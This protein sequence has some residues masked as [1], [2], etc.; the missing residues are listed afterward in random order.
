MSDG[1]GT[2][3]GQDGAG[4]PE[5][6]T[7]ST[8]SGAGAAPSG[9]EAGASGA[10]GEAG[11]SRAGAGAE[12]S[13]AGAGAGASRAGAGA[14]VGASRAD[15][16]AEASRAGADA[17]A[18]R[19][20]TEAD[21]VRGERVPSGVVRLL[22]HSAPRRA[23]A[24]TPL[25]L[26]L[27]LLTAV[28]ALVASAGPA[29]V[30]RLAGNALAGR[31]AEAQRNAPGLEVFATFGPADT[32]LPPS[33]A[34]VGDL[35]AT[36]HLILGSA[37]RPLAGKVA[38]DSTRIEI[39][40]GHTPTPGGEAG[41]TLVLPD[42]APDARSYVAGRP[43]APLGDSLEIAVSTRT[44]DAL[45]LRLGQRLDLKARPTFKQVD[46]PVRVVGFFTP[47]DSRL[48]REIPPLT[49][50]LQTSPPNAPPTWQAYAIIGVGS[51][52][53]IQQEQNFDLMAVWRFRL[54]FDG[55]AATPLATGRGPLGLRQSVMKYAENAAV[56][57]CGTPQLGLGGYP[58]MLGRHE[59]TE[60][61]SSGRLLATVE[62][63]ERDWARVRVLIAF[64]PASL[65][66]VG[67]AACAVASL[68]A[69]RRRLPELRLRRARGA[70]ALHLACAAGA[71]T[72]PLVLVGWA[73]GVLLARQS[74][75]EGPPPPGGLTALYLAL[76]V[77]LLLP[78]LTWYALRD[79]ALH[80]PIRTRA[81]RIRS[82]AR[83]RLTLEGGLLLLTGAGVQALRSRAPAAEPDLQLAVVPA[84]LGVAAVIVLVRCYPA[85]VRWAARRSARRRGTVPLLALSRAAQDAP[86]RA[87]VLLVLVTSLSTAVFGGL[88]ARTLAEGRRD[89]VRWQTGAN[90][91]YVA[92]SLD[93]DTARRL[94]ATP[95]VRH[96]VLI[97]HRT[98]DLRD[99][100]TGLG[101]GD[102]ALETL[103]G[104]ALR[105]ADP[106]SAVARALAGLPPRQGREIPVLADPPLRRGNVYLAALRG[107]EARVKVVGPLPG[108]AGRDPA[109]GPLR[110]DSQT[111]LLLADESA[112]RGLG[113][114]LPTV[115]KSALL[116]YGPDID[117]AALRALVPRA[118][119]SSG[120]GTLSILADEEAAID[121]DQ[122]LA[123][124]TTAYRLCTALTVLLALFALVLDLLVSAPERGR[125]AARLRTMGL[126]GRATGALNLVQLLPMTVAAALG[127]AALGL[128]L[129]RLLGDALDLRGFTGGPFDPVLRTDY[130]ATA[131]LGGGFLLLV[132]AAVAVETALAGHRTLGTVLR[133]GEQT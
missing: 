101:V 51:A 74:A 29:V 31:L 68:L 25:R 97:T 8:A 41:F 32:G 17:G 81:R 52:E 2:P 62:K 60:L 113:L 77:W 91:S 57:F 100:R 58:C 20:G 34:I 110:G 50:P 114:G 43:P 86:S 47:K 64:A 123:A 85:P 122:V 117:A 53:R 108:A 76:A 54:R 131:V 55:A 133:L 15:T 40:G 75:P 78:A 56:Q 26:C 89:A 132:A 39:R 130:A 109:L 92:E 16:A 121:D 3:G 63:F 116:L 120:L 49:T 83:R 87:L 102:V 30:D 95:G 94:A 9:A 71:G 67:L 96:R 124:L 5:G 14:A 7:R 36:R 84:L 104:G 115:R 73:A 13:R 12:T 70:S 42:D 4:G 103:D 111:P 66:C 19:A 44:R 128:L 125:T 127:G 98:A 46:G 129:P 48:L 80:A 24:E 45:R 88:V 82:A 61:L 10:G 72:A 37:P 90:A 119:K 93:A 118:D 38:Y 22:R 21:R 79:G 1:R 23:L 6:R 126:G 65:F 27:A 35:L 112:L 28:L 105:E 99:G 11:A 107:A 18:S 106:H 69:L 59:S 33:G